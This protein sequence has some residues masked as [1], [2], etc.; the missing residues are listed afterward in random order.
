M[1]FRNL[2]HLQ[3]S[4]TER[5]HPLDSY[6][7]IASELPK[8]CLADLNDFWFQN[9][10]P[11]VKKLQSVAIPYLA[12]PATSSSSERLFSKARK[13][14]ALYRVSLSVGRLSNCV[15][16]VANPDETHAATLEFLQNEG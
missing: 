12:T 4:N 9:P 15:M 16:I 13:V 14:Q 1:T 6:M 2:V 8:N 7:E 5:Q 10:T 3:P 11:A